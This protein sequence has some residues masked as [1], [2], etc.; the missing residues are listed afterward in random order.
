M[1]GLSVIAGAPGHD[2]SSS[3]VGSAVRM[4]LDPMT[5]IASVVA[6][7]GNPAPFNGD[8]FGASVAIAANWAVVATPYDDLA[9][10]DAG[11]AY[12]VCQKKGG[13]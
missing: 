3:L 1:R 11:I 8:E 12:I 13:G 7:V 9:G 5:G 2:G 4:E 6:Q 10:V